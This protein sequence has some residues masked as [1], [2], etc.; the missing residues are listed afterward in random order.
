MIT[1]ILVDQSGFDPT[2]P[3]ES[4]YAVLDIETDGP[5]LYMVEADFND[6]PGDWQLVDTMLTITDDF[7]R[8]HDE[9]YENAYTNLDQLPDWPTFLW[10]LLNTPVLNWYW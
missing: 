3:E 5:F 10:D 6:P 4:N 9:V 2:D 8:E 1:G 7:G